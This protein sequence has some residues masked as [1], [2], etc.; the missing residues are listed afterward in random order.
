MPAFFFV[1]STTAAIAFGI[2]IPNL[3]PSDVKAEARPAIVFNFEPLAPVEDYARFSTIQTMN[4][5]SQTFEIQLLRG[6]EPA[7]LKSI[8]VGWTEGAGDNGWS[9][10][11]LHYPSGIH[12][13][14]PLGP[15]DDTLKTSPVA[16][17]QRIIDEFDRTNP[18]HLSLDGSDKIIKGQAATPATGKSFFLSG[19]SCSASMDV[20]ELSQAQVGLIPAEAVIAVGALGS[21]DSLSGKNVAIVES[22]RSLYLP[23]TWSAISGSTDF[24]APS[25]DPEKT[26][27]VGSP[28]AV[29]TQY[30]YFVLEDSS[31]KRW[32]EIKFAAATLWLGAA[33]GFLLEKWRRRQEQSESEV[34]RSREVPVVGPTNDPRRPRLKRNGALVTGFLAGVLL[35]GSFLASRKSGRAPHN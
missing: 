14:D 27:S 2:V 3:P 22:K 8:E 16:P 31:R 11:L 6:N 35:T 5:V 17:L 19:I 18:V 7:A 24:F 28:F 20:R 34:E 32:D 4:S 13:G 15:E 33:I 23:R 30:D 12:P 9:C 21:S 25:I 10:Y 1:V 26:F 29:D